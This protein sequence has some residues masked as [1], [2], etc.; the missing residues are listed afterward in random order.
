MLGLALT[1]G[2]VLLHTFSPR[3]PHN[4]AEAF[5]S[6]DE[7][8][9]TL[10]EPKR[11]T[12]WS[13]R[14]PQASGL[15]KRSENRSAGAAGTGDSRRAGAGDSGTPSVGQLRDGAGAQCEEAECRKRS[16]SV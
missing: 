15:A 11:C 13:Q 12:G 4:A 2:D 9:E 1:G 6:Q 10:A 7:V 3:K 5:G 8:A 16:Q 14:A